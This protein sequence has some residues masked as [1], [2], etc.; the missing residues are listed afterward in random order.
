[1]AMRAI[2]VQLLLVV[3]CGISIGGQQELLA[4]VGVARGS[5]DPDPSLLQLHLF[6]GNGSGIDG[7]LAVPG[8][9]AVCL[10]GSRAGAYWRAGLPGNDTNV[11]LFLQGP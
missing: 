6:G 3:F 5:P 2:P 10:D 8:D 7:K 11:V 4:P 9:D 1:M